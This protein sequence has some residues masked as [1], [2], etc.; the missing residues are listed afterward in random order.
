MAVQNGEME[1]IDKATI[2]LAAT[3]PS[4]NNALMLA[5]AMGRTELVS[6]FVQQD[7]SLD[8]QNKSGDTALMM[9]S[10]GGHVE[11]MRSILTGGGGK[12]KNKS[13]SRRLL[14][15]ERNKAGLDS[16][17]VSL[18]CP[19]QSSSLQALVLLLSFVPKVSLSPYLLIAIR[20]Q[21]ILAVDFLLFGG[22]VPSSNL[23][24]SN[25]E[26]QTLVSLARA[27][28]KLSADNSA[29]SIAE[30]LNFVKCANVDVALAPLL[31]ASRKA[32]RKILNPAVEFLIM[33]Y[34]QT[35]WAPLESK[36]IRKKKKSQQSAISVPGESLVLKEEVSRLRGENERLKLLLVDI[37][38]VSEALDIG[39]DNYCGRK[40]EQLSAEQLGALKRVHVQQVA[41]IDE[42]LSKMEVSRLVELAIA[43]KLI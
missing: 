41:A 32:I 34:Y 29:K 13:E 7:S 27:Q 31:K 14:I 12:E 2:D 1:V 33:D 3:N 26:I 9:A 42:L 36:K 16:I 4:G 17:S 15:L 6:R 37:C 5:C 22:A 11:C 40:L 24:C 19:N 39:L 43:D 21:N 25:L 20:A 35:N 30:N 28:S 8:W 38:P 23:E 10:L 18:L